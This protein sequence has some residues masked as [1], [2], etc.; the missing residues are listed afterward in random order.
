MNGS[1]T[2]W[3]RG[4]FGFNAEHDALG[5]FLLGKRERKREEDHF[6]GGFDI[7][8]TNALQHMLFGASS[9]S[10]GWIQPAPVP[11]PSEEV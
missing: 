5:H 3:E 9:T 1:L 2:G 10:P 8:I 4:D 11:S 7:T 6:Q